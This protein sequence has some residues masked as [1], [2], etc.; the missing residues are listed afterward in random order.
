MKK[1]ILSIAIGL[2]GMTTNAQTQCYKDSLAWTL[3]GGLS[4][5]IPFCG[6][7]YDN[8][9]TPSNIR[10]WGNLP[11]DSLYQ[12]CQSSWFNTTADRP[13]LTTDRFTIQNK[14]MI[15][16]GDDFL[17]YKTNGFNN[18]GG[19][20]NHSFSFSVWV[21][22][23]SSS[24]GSVR[25]IIGGNKIKSYYS[26]TAVY[27][28][29]P[30][31]YLLNNKVYASVTTYDANP[32]PTSVSWQPNSVEIG[33]IN[34]NWTNYSVTFNANT[35]KA[36]FYVNGVVVDSVTQ[37]SNGA[38]IMA[39]PNNYGGF[40]FDLNVGNCVGVTY[41][42]GVYTNVSYNNGF[43]GKIDDI[44]FYNRVLTNNEVA[45]IYQTS[46]NY[47]LE[48]VDT[49]YIHDTITIV[50]CQ[51]YDTT[52]VNVYD[53]IQVPFYYDAP[54]YVY[55]T[56]NVYDTIRVDV[57]DTIYVNVNVYDTIQVTDTLLIDWRTIGL[58]NNTTIEV[59]KDI[60]VYPI[61]TQ[62]MLTIDIGDMIQSYYYSTI[63]QLDYYIYN[64]YG[65][66]VMGGQLTQGK[67]D[68]D[69]GN[70]SSGNYKLV[71]DDHVWNL[72][73]TKNIVIVN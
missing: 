37:P 16:D 15:F 47:D 48:K 22:P 10:R 34:T 29:I 30:F 39:N 1:L 23:N 31:L 72:P 63:V 55:D 56:I 71:L 40:D 35:R 3:Q 64:Q 13:S 65:A 60:K 52:Y 11:T 19:N 49:M 69:V 14:A 57:Y 38:F 27:G 50:N 53:T 66:L 59:F 33:V 44:L 21:K 20:G 61:P 54:I 6:N 73:T 7:N 45:S 5:Y 67:T 28:T 41:N 25:A 42:C 36:F 17:T 26:T 58:Y 51:Y 8:S 2:V 9:T 43:E 12:L 18:G 70:L 46:G 24:V 68:I 32:S 4:N 62:K